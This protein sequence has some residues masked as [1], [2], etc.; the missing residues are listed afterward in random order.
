MVSFLGL[1]GANDP[2]ESWENPPEAQPGWVQI[3]GNVLFS[4]G[5]AWLLFLV[6]GGFSSGANITIQSKSPWWSWLG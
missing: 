2:E 5:L 1:L 4:L 6:V 3:G